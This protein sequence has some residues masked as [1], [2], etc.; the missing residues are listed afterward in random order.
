MR[1]PQLGQRFGVAEQRARDLFGAVLAEPNQ[2][3]EAQV[4]RGHGLSMSPRLEPK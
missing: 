2:G 1:Q 4:F 3:Q